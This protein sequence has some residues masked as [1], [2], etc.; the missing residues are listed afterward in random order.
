MTA[1]RSTNGR[2]T[3][4]VEA[5]ISRWALFWRRLSTR[6]ALLRLTDEQLRDIGLTRDEANREAHRPFWML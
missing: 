1:T 4:R 3:P 2:V 6:Q 5:N